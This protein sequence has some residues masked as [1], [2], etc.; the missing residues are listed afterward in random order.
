[1]ASTESGMTIDF[2]SLQ[3]ENALSPMETTDLG[4]WTDFNLQQPENALFPMHAVPSTCTTEQICFLMSFHGTSSSSGISTVLRTVSSP[5]REL[6]AHLVCPSGLS[7]WFSSQLPGEEIL[8]I[9]SFEKVN[10][11]Q[12]RWSWHYPRFPHLHFVWLKSFIRCLLSFS[13]IFCGILHHPSCFD[14]C[15]YC[16]CMIYSLFVF[17]TKSESTWL[18]LF[19][20]FCVCKSGCDL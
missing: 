17:R 9:R 12:K 1:M 19:N 10:W 16:C 15:F 14:L 8:V 4:M 13:R 2:N 5:V 18:P 11:A 20:Y 7:S 3:K 6:N